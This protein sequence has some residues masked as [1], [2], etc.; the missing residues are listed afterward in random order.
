MK[1]VLWYENKLIVLIL[2]IVFFPIGLYALWKNDAI[3]KSIKIVVTVF[4]G[5]LIIGFAGSDNKPSFDLKKEKQIQLFHI[6]YESETSIK[7][8]LKDPQSYELIDKDYKFL[9]DTIYEVNITYSAT[10]SFGGRIQNK[11]LKMGVLK[12][13]PKDTT[14]TNVVTFEK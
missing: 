13:N 3:A 11:Y 14:F 2:L 5:L 9:S 7:E 12:F 4:F 1:K 8:N 10:N 6:A